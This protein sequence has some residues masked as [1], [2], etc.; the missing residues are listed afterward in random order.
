MASKLRYAVTGGG[1]FVGKAL[2]RSLRQE[3]HE[4][5]S[6]SRSTYPELE[7]LGV[8]SIAIDLG[9]P[10][11]DVVSIIEGC[12]AVFHTAAKVDMWG[13]YREFF[14]S[15]VTATRNLLDA[16]RKAG[17]RKFIYTSS[18]S[19]VAGSGEL[20][21][22][23][24][25]QP[26]PTS[27]SAHYPATKAIAERE[28]LSANTEHLWTIALRPHLIF[29]PGDRNFVPTI[30]ERARQ[31]RLTR[32]GS[33]QNKVDLCFIEDCVRAHRL[34]EQA[35]TSNPVS[36]G[37]VYFISQGE[38]VLLWQWIDEVLRRN[39]L[40]PVGRAVPSWLALT[41]ARLCEAGARLR[42]SRAVPFLTTFLVHEMCSDHYFD[43]SAAR[44]DLGFVPEFSVGQAVALSFPLPDS[45]AGQPG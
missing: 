42:R 14:R 19:V 7:V 32:V 6:L 34:A 20:R 18:P 16:S 45:R 38:P 25:S 29:G 1:G 8:Q 27:H 4:V 31:G 39:N 2:C 37:K 40:P 30:L 10:T 13:D 35:L 17:I 41:L 23:D 26:Y 28:V 33:G 22:V 12:E 36:R 11:K 44:R 43:I 5:V 3:G 15:N 21:G 24:E 9:T